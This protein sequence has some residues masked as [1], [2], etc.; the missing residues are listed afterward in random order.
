MIG[1]VDV[2]VGSGWFTSKGWQGTARV[3]DGSV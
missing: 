2:V 1:T 3:E